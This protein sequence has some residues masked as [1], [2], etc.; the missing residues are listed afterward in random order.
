MH[1]ASCYMLGHS[2]FTEAPQ[3]GGVGALL[4]QSA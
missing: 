1:G 3:K 2:K 4:G